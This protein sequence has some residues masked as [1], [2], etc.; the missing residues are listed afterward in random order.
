LRSATRATATLRSATRTP[1]SRRST[2]AADVR[3]AASVRRR[4]I[5]SGIRTTGKTDHR[6][7]ET[8]QNKL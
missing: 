6:E 7:N 1:S 4:R 5:L 3:V 8:T 2:R